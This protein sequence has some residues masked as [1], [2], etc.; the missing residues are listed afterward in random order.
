MIKYKP[1]RKTL[2]IIIG[3]LTALLAYAL[4]A[5]PTPSDVEALEKEVQANEEML[6][7]QN[8]ELGAMRI[9]LESLRLDITDKDLEI[10]RLKINCMAYDDMVDIFDYCLTYIY[11]IQ[12]RMDNYGVAY[13]EFIVERIM[14]DIL[15]EG[16]E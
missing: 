15:T 10:V 6:R 5:S 12:Q 8:F 14:V 13:P 11:V 7:D 16:V 2:Y 4:L 1:Q 9:K 3:F